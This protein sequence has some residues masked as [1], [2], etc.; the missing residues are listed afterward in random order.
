MRNLRYC[1]AG[2][3]EDYHDARVG[4]AVLSE[5]PATMS[6]RMEDA[7]RLVRDL[8]HEIAQ[9]PLVGENVQTPGGNASHQAVQYSAT[10]VPLSSNGR[11]NGWLHVVW[12]TW[13]KKSHSN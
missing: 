5:L 1:N 9:L 10:L 12:V 4:E 7:E 11:C 2:E 3:L 8:H 13:P 6:A